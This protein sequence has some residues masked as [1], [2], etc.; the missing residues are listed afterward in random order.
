MIQKAKAF[1]GDF[2][3]YW[4]IPMPGR[5]MTFKEIAA[6]AGGGIGAEYDEDTTLEPVLD[7]KMTFEDKNTDPHTK[8]SRI[9]NNLCGSSFFFVTVIWSE[10]VFSSD[11]QKLHLIFSA[12]RVKL[13]GQQTRLSNREAR[14]EC[15][16]T[17]SVK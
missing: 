3:T 13:W 9:G 1:L 14:D 16:K 15:A 6:Y 17:R 8:S 5:Y 7:Y 2:R 4:N 10:I 11:F 12:A